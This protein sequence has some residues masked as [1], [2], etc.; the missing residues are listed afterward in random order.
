MGKPKKRLEFIALMNELLQ[1]TE[2]LTGRKKGD[3]KVLINNVKQYI[4]S[5]FFDS[6]DGGSESGTNCQSL[7]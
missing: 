2:K 1:G 6:T 4:L 7:T 3:K 5:H